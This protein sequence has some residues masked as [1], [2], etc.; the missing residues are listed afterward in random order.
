[1]P[2]VTIYLNDKAASQ[3]RQAAKAQGLSVSRWIAN[4]VEESTR[5]EWPAEVLALAGTWREDDFPSAEELRASHPPDRVQKRI[6]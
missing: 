1:M 3:A 6:K 5:D 2:Q 4:R